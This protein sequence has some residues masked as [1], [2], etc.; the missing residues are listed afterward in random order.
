MDCCHAA[1]GIGV[2]VSSTLAPEESQDLPILS[3]ASHCSPSLL[4]YGYRAWECRL[5][6]SVRFDLCVQIWPQ[7]EF[8]AMGA[9]SATLGPGVALQ[10]HVTLCLSHSSLGKQDR[11]PSHEEIF[12]YVSLPT[13]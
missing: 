12:G 3:L 6:L 10:A 9:G 2:L 11:S 5:P 1:H 4:F 7:A 13:P 8:C